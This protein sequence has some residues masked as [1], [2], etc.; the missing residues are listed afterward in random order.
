MYL[1]LA[2]Y[3]PTGRACSLGSSLP[4][5]NMQSR[6]NSRSSLKDR[7]PLSPWCHASAQANSTPHCTETSSQQ[8]GFGATGMQLDAGCSQDH[9][10]PTPRHASLDGAQ[11]VAYPQ[12]LWSWQASDAGLLHS[13]PCVAPGH[14]MPCPAEAMVSAME[15]NMGV[16]AHPG[17]RHSVSSPLLPA[18]LQSSC[19]GQ[20]SSFPC[21]AVAFDPLLLCNTAEQMRGSQPERRRS[22]SPLSRG[23]ANVLPMVDSDETGVP[24]ISCHTLAQLHT[25]QHMFPISSVC[26]IDCRY[27]AVHSCCIFQVNVTTM[28]ISTIF[29]TV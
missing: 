16:E 20:A 29:C 14:S 23:P 26:M 28:T 5:A 25:G 6:T 8:H 24:S 4:A 19:V 27:R 7:P 10:E 9:S 1:T 21:S 15:A 2:G 22:F 13:Q 12:H 3:L 17:G 18:S 11:I